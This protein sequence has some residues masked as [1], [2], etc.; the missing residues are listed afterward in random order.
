MIVPAGTG[1]KA[2]GTLADGAPED[3]PVLE[4]F[5]GVPGQ[6]AAVAALRAAAHRPVHAYLFCGP[7]GTGRRAAARAFA[8][9]LLCRN[10]GCGHCDDCRRALAGTHPDLVTLE[11][12]GAS[13]SVDE[14]RQLTGLAQRRPF[15]AERQVLVV[16]DVHLAVRSAPALLKTVEEPPATTVFVLLAEH[17]PPELA[18]VASRCV[19]IDFP[20]LAAGEVARWLAEAGLDPS[21][22]AQVADGASGNLERAM[23]LADDGGYAARLELWR[24]IP[25]R[26]D[27]HGA[28]AG[29]LARELLASAEAGLEPL[30]FRHAEE[31]REVEAQAEAAG[32][33][34]VPGRRELTDRQHRE[35]RRWRTDEIRTGLAVLARA[36]RDRLA[37]GVAGVAGVGPAAQGYGPGDELKGYEA[38]V[39]L[40]TAAAASLHHNPNETLLLEALLVRLG[41]LGG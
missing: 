15:S 3:P 31:L 14:A 33:R 17:V 19:R 13:V 18:T 20:P 25:S 39:D 28:T 11:R 21:R 26:L 9:S 10:G 22:A 12:T 41:R 1:A 24:S 34:G 23:L 6:E 40:V 27:G 36:Y 7:P 29:A 35:E 38:A 2:P 16:A 8:A 4:L 32:E 37:D 30:R 5:A